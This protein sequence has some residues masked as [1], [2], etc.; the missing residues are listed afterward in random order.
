MSLLDRLKQMI[1]GAE[2][3]AAAPAVAA[4]GRAERLAAMRAEA[5]QRRRKD[6]LS[7][8]NEVSHTIGMIV[9]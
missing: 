9:Q 1:G 7:H 6:T 4:Q 2:Q 5:R 3:A 8:A